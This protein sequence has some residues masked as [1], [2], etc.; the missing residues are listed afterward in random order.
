VAARR[1][2]KARDKIHFGCGRGI[3]ARFADKNMRPSSKLPRIPIP[4]ERNKLKRDPDRLRRR[5]RR[6]LRPIDLER[7]SMAKSALAALA[8]L[9]LMQSSFPAMAVERG[10]AVSCREQ[11]SKQRSACQAS[12]AYCKQRLNACIADCK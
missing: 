12:S 5:G 4:Q 3:R 1:R 7:V 6:R 9:V 10:R 2:S 11:C 8:V